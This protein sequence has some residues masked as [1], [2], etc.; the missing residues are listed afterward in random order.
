MTINMTMICHFNFHDLRIKALNLCDLPMIND[1]L[2]EFGAHNLRQAQFSQDLWG[3]RDWAEGG[4]PHDTFPAVEPLKSFA[5]TWH[6][7]RG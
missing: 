1:F 2:G 5:A 3:D 7:S 4:A 6:R